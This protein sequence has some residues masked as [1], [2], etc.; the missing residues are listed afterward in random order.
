VG[1]SF[2]RWADRSRIPIIKKAITHGGIREE[3]IPILGDFVNEFELFD[4]DEI[5]RGGMDTDTVY[6]CTTKF[7]CATIRFLYF[8]SIDSFRVPYG[9]SVHPIS[10]S[11]SEGLSGKQAT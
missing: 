6:L 2:G 7:T 8:T 5:L 4:R 9:R 3:T 10:S 11:L 1:Y